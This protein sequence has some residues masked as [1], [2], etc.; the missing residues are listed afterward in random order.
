MPT[1]GDSDSDRPP[2]RRSDGLSLADP[3]SRP[4]S[5]SSPGS[6][7][8]SLGGHSF[9]TLAGDSAV[10]FRSDTD[11]AAA[12]AAAGGDDS[13]TGGWSPP[14]AGRGARRGSLFSTA[15]DDAG[16][17]RRGSRAGSRRQRPESSYD[18]PADADAEAAAAAAAAAAAFARVSPRRL[19]R[20]PLQS[21]YG[22][23]AAAGAAGAEAGGGGGGE[24]DA[25]AAAMATLSV[26]DIPVR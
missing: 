8:P 2:P 25:A 1:T 21:S 18:V 5:P 15:E 3:D 4:Q 9:R 13:D 26:A 16:R 12:A 10:S 22:E 7:P 14:P 24:G 23:P 17:P 11:A 20:A 6:P 19:A